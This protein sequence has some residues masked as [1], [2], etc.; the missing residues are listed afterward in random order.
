MLWEECFPLIWFQTEASKQKP[1]SLSP[2]NCLV[3]VRKPL[4]DKASICSGTELRLAANVVHMLFFFSS[5]AFQLSC[6]ML[7][8]Y[9]QIKHLLIRIFRKIRWRSFIQCTLR[10][11]HLHLEKEVGLFIQCIAFIWVL[12]GNWWAP[13]FLYCQ[14]VRKKFS[15]FGFIF[16]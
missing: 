7:D 16:L 14:M 6:L 4:N 8:T 9:L 10:Q 5:F 11:V 15:S 1:L 3:C 2:L 13:S 12:L